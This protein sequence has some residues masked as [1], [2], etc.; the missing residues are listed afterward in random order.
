MQGKRLLS[1]IMMVAIGTVSMSTSTAGHNTDL[2]GRDDTK[3]LSL[4]MA[5]ADEQELTAKAMAS[6]KHLYIMHAMHAIGSLACQPFLHKYLT[7]ISSTL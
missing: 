6:S 7:R 5:A 2:D 4:I 3:E 1:L